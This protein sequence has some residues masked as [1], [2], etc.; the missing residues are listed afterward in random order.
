MEPASQGDR[1]NILGQIEFGLRTLL[2][3]SLVLLSMGINVLG[4]ANATMN[5]DTYLDDSGKVVGLHIYSFTYRT[6]P[7]NPR[8]PPI[9]EFLRNVTVGI[10]HA[11]L[12]YH[13]DMQECLNAIKSKLLLQELSWI[14]LSNINLTESASTLI[15]TIRKSKPTHLIVSHSICTQPI[16]KTLINEIRHIYI[17]ES[18]ILDSNNN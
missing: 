6:N 8:T 14:C 7:I 15:L 12:D 4:Q 18:R 1:G 17:I 9:P 10:C 2:V 16:M 5:Y 11:E 13:M 3:A